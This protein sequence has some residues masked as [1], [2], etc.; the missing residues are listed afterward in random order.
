VDRLGRIH[1]VENV[2]VADGG[3]L[4]IAGGAK[5]TLTIQANARRIAVHLASELGAESAVPD[6]G[7]PMKGKA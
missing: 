7:I 6:A 2:Y 1:T 4:P 5:P 3:F